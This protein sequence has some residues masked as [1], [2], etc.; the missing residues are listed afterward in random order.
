[1]KDRWN[2]K[3]SAPAIVA[4]NILISVLAHL[5]IVMPFVPSMAIMVAAVVIILIM[6][7]YGA[8]NEIFDSYIA[9]KKVAVV[10]GAVCLVVIPIS[11]T[12]QNYAAQIA[13]TAV[14]YMIACLGLNFQMGSTDMTNF[15]PAAFMGLGAY[16]VGVA[17]KH[18]HVSPWVG[19]LI[20]V[21]AAVAFGFVIGLPTLKTK[22]YYLSLV[23]M[24]I[25]LAFTQI[26]YI[27]PFLGGQGGLTDLASSGGR[28][29]LF[30][31]SLYKRYTVAGIRFAPQIP[32]LIFCGVVLVLL[33]Y[34]A[35]RVYFTKS[36]LSLNTIAQ[37]E[38]AANCMGIHV[39]KQ[40]LFAFVIGGVFCSIA[41]SLYAGLDAYVGPD[42]YNFSK[43]LML[44]CMVI[45]GGMDNSIG[46]IVGTFLL[47][48]I[49]EKLRD[50]GDF[51]QLVYGAILVIMLIVRPNGIIPKRVRNYCAV[52]GR[53]IQKN[54]LKAAKAKAGKPAGD[55]G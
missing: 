52:T 36:G 37:D 17:V 31:L 41:G 22:G 15:A 54:V 9:H 55:K 20:G 10:S 2:F 24:A 25:Q 32:Y 7:R 34:V 12:S 49:S 39:S 38:I 50:V 28:F 5:I 33:T 44:I 30:G 13:C 26:I 19:V 29:T 1:M 35:M 3:L 42:T 51:Q 4:C 14:V 40:K 21:A 53:T 27:T 45:L 8:V 11:L 23:T 43:S 46:I 18:F 47:T 6:D 16:G 48:V